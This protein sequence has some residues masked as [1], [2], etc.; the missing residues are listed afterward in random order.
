VA[1][2]NT[3]S[4]AS[5]KPLRRRRRKRD[6]QQLLRLKNRLLFVVKEIDEELLLSPLK[7]LYLLFCLYIVFLVWEYVRAS[8]VLNQ[9]SSP[10]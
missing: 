5:S 6:P 7:L 9:H 2:A 1:I 4:G 8:Q 3:K 10:E